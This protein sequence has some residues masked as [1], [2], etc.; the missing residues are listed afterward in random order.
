MNIHLDKVPSQIDYVLMSS[1]WSSAV[2][3]CDVRWGVSIQ[4]YGRKYDHGML[5]FNFKLRLKADRRSKFTALRN[6]E[7]IEAHNSRIQQLLEQSE[8]PQNAA[9]QLKRLTIALQYAQSMI[10]EK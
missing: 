3:S 6:P 1:R 8:A 9:E 5:K 10:P 2:R 4:V 7:N